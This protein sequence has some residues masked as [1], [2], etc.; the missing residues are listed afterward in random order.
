MNRERLIEQLVQAER[1]IK[2]NQTQVRRQVQLIARLE[3]RRYDTADAK[4]LLKQFQIELA[5]Q[6]A[7]RDSVRKRLRV[8]TISNWP[9]WRSIQ[10][11]V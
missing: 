2:Q 1:H 6:L 9:L 4:H 11:R 5:N 7:I 10:L 8:R 3:R